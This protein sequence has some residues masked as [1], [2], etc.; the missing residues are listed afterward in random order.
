MYYRLRAGLHFCVLGDRVYFLDA[1][2][3][4]YFAAAG[5]CA[6]SLLQLA[7]AGGWCEDAS[8]DIELLVARGLLEPAEEGEAFSPALHIDP[9]L[10]FASFAGKSFSW[11]GTARAAYEQLRARRMTARSTFA[12]IL[13]EIAGSRS[14]GIGGSRKTRC[15][16]EELAGFHQQA[17]LILGR[18]DLCL[19]RS[20]ALLLAAYAEGFRPRFVIGVRNH[21]FAAHCWVQAGGTVLN[22]NIDHVR[23]FTPILVQ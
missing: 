23:L 18:A 22:D 15:S 20:L 5:H 1:V 8:V 13:A 4:R 6:S 11:F 12:A 19:P 7:E 9:P 14:I 21:P 2:T 3:G 10:G 16:L 17:G